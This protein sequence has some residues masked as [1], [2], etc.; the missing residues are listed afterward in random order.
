[1]TGTENIKNA[2]K[3]AIG[4]G[5]KFEDALEDG[6]ISMTEWFGL[7]LKATGIVGVIKNAT[8]AW[9]EFEDLN[10]EERIEVVNFV[11]TELDLENDQV[12]EYIEK[13][14]ELLVSLAL[15]F[16]NKE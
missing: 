10:E 6:K 3:W 2:L 14:F 13:A 11:Q 8:E 5:M 16:T 4:F 1:M 15:F 12:E 7:G 9:D